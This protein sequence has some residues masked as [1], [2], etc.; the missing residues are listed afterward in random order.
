VEETVRSFATT[1][2]SEEVVASLAHV[3]RTGGRLPDAAKMEA[4]A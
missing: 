3:L 1:P 2:F 4:R